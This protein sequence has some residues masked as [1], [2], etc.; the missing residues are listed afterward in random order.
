MRCRECESLVWDY[1]DE[2]L[3]DAQRRLVADHL[4]TCPQCTGLYQQMRSLPIPSGQLQ[5]V[6][7]PRDF[8]ARLME[9]IAPLPSP[10][11]LAARQPLPKRAAKVRILGVKSNSLAK[12]RANAFVRYHV[13]DGLRKQRS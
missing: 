3:P 7:V 2:T 8:T 6:P 10:N 9:R 12:Q 11:E 1:L 4:A 13:A 5:P